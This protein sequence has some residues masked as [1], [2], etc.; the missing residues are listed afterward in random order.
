[1]DSFVDE[2][3]YKLLEADKYTFFVLRRILGTECE[4]IA[5]DHEKLIICHS[6]TPYPVWVWTSNDAD[7]TELERAYQALKKNSFI[8]AEH[9]FNLKY[10]LADY[11]TKRAADEGKEIAIT[12][13]MLAYDCLNP[14]EPEPVEGNIHKCTYDD[15][16]TLIEF[17][18]GFHVDTGVDIQSREAYEEHAK[19]CIEEGRTFFWQDASGKLVAC[20]KYNP[21]EDMAS[22]NLVYTLPKER[23][24]HYAENLVYQVTKLAVSEGLS[25][26]VYADADYPASNE[27]YKKIG[28]VLRGSLCTIGQVV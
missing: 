11:I 16:E 8:D 12:I 13:N 28:Y 21:T 2:R 7:E 6:K 20:C 15:Y 19:R 17:M 22:I 4:F 14:I 1:M 26:M 24:K 10:S 25:P 27:C 9:S 3:D 18:D 23:R 5:S